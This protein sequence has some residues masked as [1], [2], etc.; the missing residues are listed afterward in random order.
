MTLLDS[1]NMLLGRRVER[2]DP[3]LTAPADLPATTHGSSWLVQ[4]RWVAVIGQLATICFTRYVLDVK[5]PMGILFAVV[6]V[7]AIS[8]TALAI[9][10]ASQPIGDRLD[11]RMIESRMMPILG[12]VQLLDLILLTV[13]LSLSGGPTNPFLVFYFVNLCLSAVVLPRAWAWVISAAG[14][15]CFVAMFFTYRP[16]PEMWTAAHPAPIQPGSP[17]TR[18]HWGLLVAF[19]A[20]DIVIVYFTSLLRDQLRKRG[21]ELRVMQDDAARAHKLEALGTLAAGA[22]HELANPLGTIAVVAREVERRVAGTV[23]EPRVA[24]DIALI[25]SELETCRNILKRMSA[26]AGQAMGEEIV[27]ASARELLEESLE[28]LRDSGRVALNV[29]ASVENVMLQIPLAGLAQA[30]RGII[31]NALAA[32]A[33]IQQVKLSAERVGDR[34]RIT[35]RDEGI[36]MHPTVLARV[37]DPFFTTKDPGSGTGLGVFLARAVVERLGGGFSINSISGRGTTVTIVLPS[38]NG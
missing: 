32:S 35:V 8:N 16:L 15:V 24:S 37:G 29:D 12:L 33:S 21:Y 11:N 31:Q 17:L 27:E 34:V 3:L 10:S 13:L 30:I 6:A 19:A 36:G 25:R 14:I 7:T 38:A 2:A 23:A 1:L 22:A 20:C 9:W 18:G 4:L 28:G 5:L 26:D